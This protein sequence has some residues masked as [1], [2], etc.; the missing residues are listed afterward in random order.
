MARLT[1]LHLITHNIYF[2]WVG[3]VLVDQ[4]LQA[5]LASLLCCMMEHSSPILYDD[6]IRVYV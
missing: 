6:S 2:L 5:L 4:D 1:P 3:I